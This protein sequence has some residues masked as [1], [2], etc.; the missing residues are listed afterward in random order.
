ML[1][2]GNLVSVSCS[3]SSQS[4]AAVVARFADQ[5]RQVGWVRPYRL[6]RGPTNVLPGRSCDTAYNVCRAPK[7]ASVDT[8]WSTAITALSVNLRPEWPC[9]LVCDRPGWA[10]SARSEVAS[11]PRRRCNSLVNNRL[12]SFDWP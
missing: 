11:T 2:S 3:D 8:T 1:Q 4:A 9:R 7:S 12:A 6:N 5:L 10:A